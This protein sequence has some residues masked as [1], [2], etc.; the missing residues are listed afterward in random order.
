MSQKDEKKLPEHPL[1]FPVLLLVLVYIG[2]GYV[3][4]EEHGAGI[5]AP[6][7]RQQ[8]VPAAEF[9][10]T[11]PQPAAPV[12]STGQRTIYL[13]FDD[14]PCENTPAVLD[15]LDRYGAKATFFT[16]GA[17]VDRYPETTADIVKRGNLIA[18]HTYT[19]DFEKCY[20]SADAFIAETERWKGAVRKACGSLPERLCVRFPGGSTTKYAADVRDEIIVRLNAA[21]CRWFDWNAADNDKWDK[22]NTKN[23]PET[24][25][26]MES[27][28]ECMGWYQ[29]TPD[30][31]VVFLFHDTEKGSVEILPDI[32]Q[33]LIN[34]GYSFRLLNEHP[35]WG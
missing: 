7:D 23:L 16:V 19:H 1:L 11:E 13:T 12:R 18:C 9:P 2:V 30:I 33:D 25:Y 34:R 26:F 5:A 22:G 6:S 32:L 20:A 15:I 35:D 8:T 10:G 31:P 14:G 28:R 29:D 21:G 4:H 24:Q 17:F 3:M 27:Y